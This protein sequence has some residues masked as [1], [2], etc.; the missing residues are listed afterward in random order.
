MQIHLAI[1][2]PFA[3]GATGTRL[4]H[5]PPGFPQVLQSTRRIVLRWCRFRILAAFNTDNIGNQHRMVRGYRPPRLGA[6]R[7]M[8]Q[9]V[10][11]TGLTKRPDNV[12]RVLVQA[13]VYGAVRLRARSFV[14]HT[15]TA[16]DV[17]TL[18]VDAKL[19]QLDIE[20]SRF[21]YAR[22]DIA[23]IGHL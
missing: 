20:A 19:M 7:W 22:G 21:T 23:N 6:R 4:M 10:P 8:R 14:V 13:V 11:C 15:Q 17:E 12:V 16:A 2:Q 9:T 3:Q 5:L 1:V 18:D